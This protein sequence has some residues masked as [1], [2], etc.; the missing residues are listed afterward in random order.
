MSRK[1]KLYQVVLGSQVVVD[2]LVSII[3]NYAYG[4]F[5]FYLTSQEQDEYILN[6][7]KK[8]DWEKEIKFQDEDDLGNE[9]DA[10][11]NRLEDYESK[12]N[13]LPY[14]DCVKRS[15]GEMRTY[16]L[17]LAQKIPKVDINYLKYQLNISGQPELQGYKK[18]Q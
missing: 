2:D 13:T 15:L 17:Q 6:L 3:V 4:S 9:I 5:F 7:L 8:S 1:E 12:K 10:I 14:Y 18:I 11:A 16:P